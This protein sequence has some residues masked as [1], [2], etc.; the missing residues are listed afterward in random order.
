MT[1]ESASV[2]ETLC[3]GEKI[4]KL[5]KAGDVVALDGELGAGKTTFVKGIARGLGIKPEVVVSPTFVLIG[6]Y[7]GREKV[8]HLDW[9]RLDRVEGADARLASECFDSQAVTLV[10]WASRGVEWLPAER[11]NVAIRHSGADRRSISVTASGAQPSIVVELLK[12]KT[13][14]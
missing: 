10:E 8:F 7:E 13:L 14:K 1:F 4:G 6:E 3:F 9:Y 5:L 11:L 2:A 12:K